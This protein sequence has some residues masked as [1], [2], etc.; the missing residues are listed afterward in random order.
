[1]RLKAGLTQAKLAELA[2]VTQAYVAK[3]EAGQADPKLSTLRR[4][5]EAIEREFFA[6]PSIAVERIATKPVIFVKP[7]DAIGKAV[8]LME[9]RNISQLPVIASGKQVGSLTETTLL[10]RVASGE[11]LRSLLKQSVSKIMEEPFPMVA[12]E[13]DLRSVYPLLEQRPAIL[14]T[15]LDKIVGIITRADIFKL[16]AVGR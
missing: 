13:I 11:K 5:I 15:D 12:K 2:G 16:R 14:I 6:S 3:I 4:I 9:K 10:R 7:S 1:M 8:K